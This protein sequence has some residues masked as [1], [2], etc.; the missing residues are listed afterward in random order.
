MDI[1]NYF[2]CGR[3]WSFFDT[4]RHGFF[5]V[6]LPS[7]LQ[8]HIFYLPSSFL[9]ACSVLLPTTYPRV[10]WRLWQLFCL[11]ELQA[12]DWGGLLLLG[13]SGMCLLL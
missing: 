11:L 5:L 1:Y 13:G 12:L 4:S 8:R 2:I 9:P 3:N 10:G 6:P 7:R